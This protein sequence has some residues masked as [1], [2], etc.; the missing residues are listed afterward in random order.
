MLSK[1]ASIFSEVGFGSDLVCAKRSNPDPVY[2]W[3]GSATLSTTLYVLTSCLSHVPCVGDCRAAEQGV[4]RRGP[5]PLGHHGRPDA[6]ALQ[7][8]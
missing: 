3:A 6:H 2:N 5:R 8:H 7:A 4:P 1:S